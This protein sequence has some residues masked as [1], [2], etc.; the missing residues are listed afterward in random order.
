MRESTANERRSAFR[1]VIEI[2]N[3]NPRREL[4]RFVVTFKA[5]HHRGLARSLGH[6]SKRA[7]CTLQ[8]P[9]NNANVSQTLDDNGNR[10]SHS[11][12]SGKR[13]AFRSGREKPTATQ[14]IS[15]FHLKTVPQSATHIHRLA[16]VQNH[17]L[18][19]GLDQCEECAVRDRQ[20]S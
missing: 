6:S 3:D 9:F 20:G 8:N 13:S 11:A 19:H 5:S 7:V 12:N 4:R 2:P 1:I 18:V 14:V 10:Y 15:K 17:R 16:C